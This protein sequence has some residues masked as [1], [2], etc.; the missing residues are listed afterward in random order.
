MIY[1]VVVL[2]YVFNEKKFVEILYSK[3]YESIWIIMLKI[4]YD[5]SMIK[6]VK[7]FINYIFKEFICIFV[8]FLIE[9][10]VS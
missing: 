4:V 5:F 8:N 2:I 9:K 10:M 7:M 6:I 1:K 3:R